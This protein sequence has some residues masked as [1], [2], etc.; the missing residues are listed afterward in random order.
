[1]HNWVGVWSQES[2]DIVPVLGLF[3]QTRRVVLHL[4]LLL[5]GI[6]EVDS[7]PAASKF[8]TT[9]TKEPLAR[10]AGNGDPSRQPIAVGHSAA[11]VALHINAMLF[12]KFPIRYV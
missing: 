6:I 10:W 12:T 7:I 5:L 2:P 3:L 4:G 9:R 1:M 11:A 8:C